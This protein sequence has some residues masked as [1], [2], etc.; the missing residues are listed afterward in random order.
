MRTPVQAVHLG[1]LR[2]QALR[3]RIVFVIPIVLAR[4]ESARQQDE[5]RAISENLLLTL[6]RTTA[7]LPLS[8]FF[9]H[10]S[11][12]YH[13]ELFYRWS[14]IRPSSDDVERS[15]K[16]IQFLALQGENFSIDHDICGIFQIELYPPH[17]LALSQRVLDMGAVIKARQIADQ[18]QSPNRSPANVFHQAIIDFSF[19]SDH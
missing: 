14:G 10:N 9:R 16:H 6:F 12:L 2:R 7:L 1:L 4:I 19:G 5:R 17:R 3:E 18:S 13:D 15:G 11:S 8:S